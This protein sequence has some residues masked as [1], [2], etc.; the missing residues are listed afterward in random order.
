MLTG[1]KKKVPKSA[2]EWPKT[3]VRRASVNNFGFGGTNVHLILENAPQLADVNKSERNSLPNGING[4]AHSVDMNAKANANAEKISPTV[5]R[6]SALPNG[7]ENVETNE[8]SIVHFPDDYSSKHSISTTTYHR[9]YVLTANHP[10]SLISQV[11]ALASYLGRKISNKRPESEPEPEP[12]EEDL[13]SNLAFTLCQR[14]SILPWKVSFTASTAKELRNLLESSDPVVPSPSRSTKA[15]TI[16]FVFTGQ[17]ANWHA[18]GR[19][20]FAVY[21]VFASTIAAA[22]AHLES[23]GAPWSLKGLIDQSI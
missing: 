12:E 16:G 7:V 11:A 13:M 2:L 5:E 4:A 18:M 22:D 10:N 14:R 21:P 3:A 23:L 20:L 8:L 15:P 9:L 17:G 1:V 6:T 19:E